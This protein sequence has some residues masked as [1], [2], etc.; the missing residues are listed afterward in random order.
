MNIE[1]ING[2]YRLSENGLYAYINGNLYETNNYVQAHE[3]LKIL[4][5]SNKFMKLRGNNEIQF[6]PL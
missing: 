3:D 1:K 5:D 2:R 6:K 4:M